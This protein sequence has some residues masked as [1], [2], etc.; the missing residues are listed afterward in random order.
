MYIIDS[1]LHTLAATVPCGSDST[2]SKVCNI[3]SSLAL[4]AV[5]LNILC[6][7]IQLL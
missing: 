4:S 1:I 3:L 6:L 5:W 7:N 2:L